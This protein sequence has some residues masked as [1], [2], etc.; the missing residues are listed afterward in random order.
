M[1]DI[2][3]MDQCVRDPNALCECWVRLS[4][5]VHCPLSPEAHPDGCELC[6]DFP[7]HLHG[8]CHPTAPLRAEMDENGRLSLYCYVPECNRFIADF[9]VNPH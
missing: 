3:E 5:G 9:D 2:P 8:R 6:G 4:N 1:S 7:V